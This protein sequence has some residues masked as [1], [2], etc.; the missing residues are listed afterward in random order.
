MTQA[1]SDFNFCLSVLPGLIQNMLKE[2]DSVLGGRNSTLE[3]LGKRN[4]SITTIISSL[5]PPGWSN[6]EFG[7]WISSHKSF[8]TL[9]RNQLQQAFSI[10]EMAGLY[11]V[12]G[13]PI[14]LGIGLNESHRKKCE[15]DPT[16]TSNCGLLIFL[17]SYATDEMKADSYNASGLKNHYRN[18]AN[19]T[20]DHLKVLLCPNQSACFKEPVFWIPILEYVTKHLMQLATWSALDSKHFQLVSTRTQKEFS[21]GYK[22]NELRMLPLFP[23]G[24]FVKGILT[25]H[26]NENE[27]RAS[28]SSFTLHTCSS[29]SGKEFTLAGSNIY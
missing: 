3:Q 11:N 12:L 13:D 7:S 20:S 21:L 15:T 8:S 6:P 18:R 19:I 25:S 9:L 4:G 14:K 27:A 29:A 17:K 23:E 24:L 16:L 28:A 22:I 10:P 26:R 2:M 5:F 1:G